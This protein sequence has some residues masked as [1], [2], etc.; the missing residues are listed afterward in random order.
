MSPDDLTADA[1]NQALPR[2][3]RVPEYVLPIGNSECSVAG[4]YASAVRR[5]PLTVKQW[6]W[7][8]SFD[9]ECYL[10]TARGAV[11]SSLAIL[12]ARNDDG[13][14]YLSDETERACHEFALI[15]DRNDLRLVEWCAEL[16][17]HMYYA[18]AVFKHRQRK[19]AKRT[20]APPQL[21]PVPPEAVPQDNPTTP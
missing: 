2:A 4:V 14:Y 1:Y 12:D 16:R 13:T 17:A 19:A 3:P 11:M 15:A 21:Q 10:L 5:L 18:M 20:P 6:R 8:M 9:L 7:I